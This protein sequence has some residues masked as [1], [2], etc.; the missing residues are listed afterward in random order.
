MSSLRVIVVGGGIGGVAC[1]VA[2]AREGI[3]VEVVEQAAELCEIGAGLQLA[4]NAMKALRHWG[5]EDEVRAVSVAS[6]SVIFRDLATGEHLFATPLGAAAGQRYGAVLQQ[7]HRADLLNI[8]GRALPD[9]T[10]RLNARVAGFSDDGD[11]VAV[12]LADGNEL[13][14]DVLIGA[15][16]L[17]SF[18][19][20]Q[21][22][23][24]ERPRFSGTVGWRAL[25]SR[26]EAEQLGFGRSCYCYLGRGRSFVLYWLRSGE[27]LN[28][29]GFVP[30]HEVH[31]ESWTEWGE[32][33]DF[34]RSFEG[35][36]PEVARLI[37]CVDRA[38]I[39][40][41]YD[42]DPLPHWTAGHVTL[43]GDAAHPLAPYLA[44]GACLAIEDAAVLAAS[45]RDGDAKQAPDA[46][47]EY[48]RLRVPR[49][50]KTQVV[51]RAAERFWHEEDPVQIAARNGR[52]RGISR[53]DPL[54]ET[55]WSWLF[56]YDPV[57]QSYSDGRS[58]GIQTVREDFHLERP[59]AQCVFEAWRGA[60]TP[61]DYAGG[62]RGV[63][64]GY[65]RFLTETC[66][67][68]AGTQH[69]EVDANGVRALWVDPPGAPRE[70]S[71]VVLYL[72]GGGYIAGSADA[73]VDMAARLAQAI[74]SRALAVDYRLAP[75]HAYPAALVDA[76][77]AY[78]WLVD[79][80][81]GA[82]RI[83]V[84]GDSAGGALAVTTVLRAR[85][86]GLPLPAGIYAMSPLADL[87]LGS[88]S[89]DRR[90]GT[91]PALNRDL[92]TDMS[93]SYLQGHDPSDPLASPVCADFTGMPPLLVHAST[94]EALWDDSQRLVDQAK[95]GAVKA[96]L[97]GF[98]DTVHAFP[99]FARAPDTAEALAE[100]GWIATDWLE[101]VRAGRIG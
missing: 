10:L 75:E 77:A 99:L 92:L 67:A 18:V 47:A 11:G 38:F 95:T 4:A 5:L 79:R 21:L 60:L 7:I 54:T 72:H 55:V 91:D 78:R 29:I 52:F 68:L 19:R 32:V 46:L 35:V 20:E 69:A 59:D 58:S 87:A 23:Q 98:D 48:E 16:G 70:G 50:T 56:D 51:A 33:A 57:S 45:L 93:G 96:R 22:L 1:G 8:L 49:A 41:V 30:A 62:W 39:T 73:G 84:A 25:I 17:G 31:R 80:A 85:D 61:T 9:D 89:I 40:G 63:R 28:A 44:Q 42:R 83:I 24:P 82:Q 14:A 81:G 27:L 65:E 101:A 43:L 53:L 76:L 94:L 88:A 97:R 66:P 15:D 90:E 3:E 34:R 37:R 26:Q 64:A 74:G 6:E 86:L 12:T 100:L 71:P 13:R 36:A 2:L